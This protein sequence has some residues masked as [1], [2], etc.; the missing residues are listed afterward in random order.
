MTMSRKIVF[1]LMIMMI[2]VSNVRA[3]EESTVSGSRKKMIMNLMD[4]RFQGGFYTFEK[5]FNQN[6]T[7]P[8]GL[9]KSCVM[10]I[11]ILSF[12]VDCEGVLTDLSIKNSLDESINYQLTKFM[13]LTRGH[14]NECKDDKYTRFEIPVQFKVKDT[15]TSTENAVLICLGESAGFVCNSDDYY[16]EKVHKFL[17]KGKGKKA[18]KYLEILIKR[19]PYNTEY[20]DMKEKALKLSE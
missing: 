1:L 18:A 10:G 17:E 9:Q 15:K 14:W 5:L 19:D 16:L 8:E 12:R 6:V 3:Q 13:E 20:Y 7:Y 2:L 11:V 4:Y